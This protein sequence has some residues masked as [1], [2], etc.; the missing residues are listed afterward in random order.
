MSS[1]VFCNY[2]KIE[3][4]RGRGCW[5]IAELSIGLSQMKLAQKASISVM[6][7]AMDTSEVGI[8]NLL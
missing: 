4:T 8:I 1:F 3:M 2:R 7:I 5:H 6:K